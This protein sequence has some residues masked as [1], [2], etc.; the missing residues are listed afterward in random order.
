MT[1]EAFNTAASDFKPGLFTDD[2]IKLARERENDMFGV[3]VSE[4][5]SRIK[6]FPKDK[7]PQEQDVA[8]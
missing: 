3:D 4:D 1:D 2:E 6:V 7:Y 8:H 5:K